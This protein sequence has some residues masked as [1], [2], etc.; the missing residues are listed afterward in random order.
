MSRQESVELDSLPEWTLM[1]TAPKT[2]AEAMKMIMECENQ[3]FEDNEKARELVGKLQAENETLKAD[4]KE[5]KSA[6]QG[7]RECLIQNVNARKIDESCIED[8]KEMID[9]LNVIIDVLKGR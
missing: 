7:C 8:Q 4:L 5:E 6:F 1:R 9:E 3:R 2:L